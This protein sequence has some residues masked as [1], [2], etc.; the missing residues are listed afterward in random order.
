MRPIV[1]ALASLL[2]IYPGC[3]I[4]DPED[5][6]PPEPVDEP[7]PVELEPPP[8]VV[9]FAI[10]E[11]V[12]EVGIPKGL[13]LVEVLGG[14]FKEDA[15][16]Y[17]G[18]S[19]SPDVTVTSSGRIFAVTP[20]HTSGR[21]DVRVVNPDD[22]IAELDDG[23][24][25]FD[26][27]VITSIE[28][29]KGPATGGVPIEVRGT[30]LSG[31]EVLLFGGQQAIDLTVIDDTTVLAVLPAH[32][33]GLADVHV[34]TAVGSGRHIEGYRFFEPPRV[35]GF[36]PLASAAAGGGTLAI[37]GAGMTPD[38]QVAVGGVPAETLAV[39]KDGT[40][41]VVRI[42]AGEPGTADLAVTTEHGAV[43][44]PGAFTY[45]DGD[46][47]LALLN[48]WPPSGPAS[49]G[50]EVMLVVQG[51]DGGAEPTV[52]LG[53]EPAKVS[54]V[55]PGQHSVLVIAPPGQAGHTVDVELTVSG[56]TY[57]LTEAYEYVPTLAVQAIDPANGPASGGNLITITGL[58][59]A[60]GD[61]EV[62]V[63]ALP[64]TEVTIEG[65][66]S[67]TARAP[68]GS[69]GY[70]DVR[71][72]VGDRHALLSQ[73][74]TFTAGETT[75][76]AI[77]PE[78]GAISGNTW[79]TLY[80]TD[81]PEYLDVR[82]G[83]EAAPW[84]ERVSPSQVVLR[85]PRAE[86]I[87]VVDIGIK[88]GALVA[89]L[90]ESYT[91]FD[92]A[93][94]WGGT[95]G[96]P[97]ARSLNVTVLEAGSDDPVEGAVVVIGD[98]D[99]P[100]YKGY[101]D[102]RGQVTL[103]GPWLTG[104]LDV[105]AAKFGYSAA[106]VI[107]FDAQNVTLF[108]VNP[109]A[110]PG[111]GGGELLPP[112]NITGTVQ[113]M[114]KYVVLPPWP[115]AQ[116]GV[117]DGFCA[118]CQTDADCAGDASVCTFVSNQQPFCSSACD[119]NSDCPTHFDCS[120]S[121]LAGA[122]CVPSP[123]A[124]QARCFVSS[125]SILSPLPLADEFNIVDIGLGEKSFELTGV[126]LGEV[127]IY[128]FG[129]ATRTF[130]E[131]EVFRP[132]VMGI[133]R[134]QFVGPGLPADPETGTPA[135]PP[136]NVQI[137]LDIPLSR[138]V[139]LIL[140]EQPLTPTGPDVTRVN[141]FLNLGS[142]GFIPLKSEELAPSVED[143]RFSGLPQ[144]L[145]GDLYDAE[146]AF[147][148]AASSNSNDTLPTSEV[149]RAGLGQLD[150]G[151][152]LHHDGASWK[153]VDSGYPGDVLD[154][155]ALA[156]DDVFAVTEQGTVL[157]FNGEAWAAQPVAKGPALN[158]IASDAKGGVI[159]V[160]EAGRILRHNG[161]G[162]STDVAP[163]NKPLRDVVALGPSSAVAVGAYVILEYTDG[164][165]TEA[166]FGPPKDLHAAWGA[167]VGDVWA[168]GANGIVLRRHAGSKKWK[169]VDVP[170]LDNLYDVWGTQDGFLVGVGAGG[171]VL[172][173]T[174]NGQ[175]EVVQTPTLRT[176]RG[177]W[178][179]SPTDVYAVGD[180][181]TVVHYDGVSWSLT[182]E[183]KIETSLRAIDGV[184]S[185][186]AELFAMGIHAVQLGPFL[187]VPIFSSPQFG[188]LWNRHDMSW[189]TD[190]TG[191][192]AS[193]NSMRIYGPTGALAWSIMAPGETRDFGLPDLG[194]IEG[195]PIFPNGQKRL[196]LYRVQHPDFDIDGYDSRVFRL[197]DWRAWVLQSFLFDNPE[198][199]VP[200]GTVPGN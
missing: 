130:G 194:K 85:S 105:S 100:Q 186:G 93:A 191:P 68:R 101:T 181:A 197:M 171:K 127:A 94:R 54:A 133:A 2:L 48:L 97:V 17:F 144:S 185:Y 81:L 199:E 71:V 138:S 183:E 83:G 140:G 109:N 27:I 14:G 117:V 169:A 50:G 124:Q 21:V 158:G 75:V 177:V 79:V 126:R 70:A 36:N 39:A 15:K 98:E 73:G 116:L 125:T 110:S 164:V 61:L 42:P 149:L 114:G 118:G 96:D 46:D 89:S 74:Y 113:G 152:Y 52:T 150:D 112:G 121:T 35:D 115:C 91:Y 76:Y 45:L 172:M 10:V 4:P 56:A 182:A 174:G 58:G 166:A 62:F 157:H 3:N 7:P 41:V 51:L 84:V 8:V 37:A 154:L 129:G 142:D 146:Y 19:E 178:G 20:P 34:I 139:S 163:T 148:A 175:F 141:A 1:A 65:D 198:A 167:G 187:R 156:T 111:E 151:S 43:D 143:V 38:T 33:A 25:Y 136:L 6:S 161:V 137:T 31:A 88:G 153:R 69:P 160:G 103:S 77:V 13:E 135:A 188:S 147:H 57:V 159:C 16:V 12:P 184:G 102:D 29:P 59:F 195:L 11:V 40:K 134:H 23:F 78:V 122:R 196:I 87:G 49:G 132:L 106:S 53:G 99:P 128:C 123:G 200:T 18:G 22:T 108:L 28:P 66:H 107:D 179:R 173:G 190:G 176:L 67:I 5:F 168:V 192:L 82:F 47:S 63:G 120:K 189:T 80:G 90:A 24:V 30:G 165:W 55:L 32:P 64:A 131:E 180:G 86:E 162:W 26:D 119:S 60:G 155:A 92:P 95:W 72:H 104:R 9:G 145:A 44:L 193:F 170:F